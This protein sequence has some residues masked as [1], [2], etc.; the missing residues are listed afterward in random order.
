[1]KLIV[2]ENQNAEEAVVEFCRTNAAEDVSACIRQL[3]PIVIDKL[4]E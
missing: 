4:G 3:L 1:V 2:Y